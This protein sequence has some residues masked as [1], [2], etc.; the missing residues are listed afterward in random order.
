[1]DS[2]YASQSPEFVTLMKRIPGFDYEKR[3]H[4]IDI[5][6]ISQNKLSSH[7]QKKISIYRSYSEEAGFTNIEDYQYHVFRSN[8]MDPNHAYV[9]HHRLLTRDEENDLLTGTYSEKKDLPRI[10]QSDPPVIWIGGEIGDI[11]E[12]TQFSES[13]G[14]SYTYR[15]VIPPKKV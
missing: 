10:H 9:P 5:L 13:T 3:D 4:N 6:L 11:V 15:I 8:I 2:K 12:I 14:T 7:I 1:M